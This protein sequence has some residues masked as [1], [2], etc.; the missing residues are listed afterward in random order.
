MFGWLL[1]IAAGL[2]SLPLAAALLDDQGDEN[3]ILLIQ[4]GGMM[5]VG[6][7]VALG[8]PGFVSGSSRRRVMLGAAYDLAAAVVGVLV[9]FVVL[10]GF[11]VAWLA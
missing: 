1:L 4:I 2:I 6:A 3:W 8:I 10:S 7:L 11:E 9:F 5:V